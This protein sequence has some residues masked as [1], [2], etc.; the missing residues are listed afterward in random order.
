MDYYNIGDFDIVKHKGQYYLE[1]AD[2][3]INLS[4]SIIESISSVEYDPQ[5][6]QMLITT[7]K[8]LD[9]RDFPEDIQIVVEEIEAA[10]N[11]LN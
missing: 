4:A 10:I 11:A 8:K 7:V 9:L 2:S 5:T 1:D 6:K 3:C